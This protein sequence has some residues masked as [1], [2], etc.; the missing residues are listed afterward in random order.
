MVG[1]GGGLESLPEGLT[2]AEVNA[3]RM[4]D[5]RLAK[6]F[7]TLTSAYQRD[8]AEGRIEGPVA[9]FDASEDAAA[10]EAAE[11]LVSGCGFEP[12]RIGGWAEVR[13]ME[14]PRRDGAVY[15][16]AYRPDDARR[17]AETAAADL[18][19]AAALATELRLPGG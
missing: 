18:D 1:C 17:I 16:E 9:M 11:E 7:N 19:R 10:A 3:R 8:V 12:V 5:A 2:A 15:G 14:A 6:A 13:L 4:P